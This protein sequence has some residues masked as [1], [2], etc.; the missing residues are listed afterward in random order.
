MNSYLKKSMALLVFLFG[1]C[2]IDDTGQDAVDIEENQQAIVN[3]AHT[4]VERQ[5]IGNCWVYAHATWAESMHKKATGQDFDISQSYWTYMHWFI[6]ILSGNF[7]DGTELGTGG[8]WRDAKDIAL[9]Y[10]LM[11]EID[12]VESDTWQEKSYR[13]A[14]ALTAMN[15]ALFDDGGSLLTPEAKADPLQVRAALDNAWGLSQE[16]R[17]ALD[18]T[19]GLALENTFANGS[20]TLAQ[21][22]IVLSPDQFEVRYTYGP[23]FNQQQPAHQTLKMAFNEWSSTTYG[24]YSSER[25]LAAL[26]RALHAQEPA[27]ISWFVDFNALEYSKASSLYGSFNLQTLT[28]AGKPG[29]Q[30]GHMTVLEDYEATVPVTEQTIE[31]MAAFDAEKGSWTHFGPFAVNGAFTVDMKG[32]GDADLYVGVNQQPTSKNY[33][34]R[35]YKTNSVESCSLSH[36]GSIY[37]SVHGYSKSIGIEIALTQTKVTGTS[38][39]KAGVTLDPQNPEDA[40]KLAAALGPDSKIVFLRI[41]NSWGGAQRYD[42]PYAPGPFAENGTFE[43]GYHD[44]YMDY[45]TASIPTV[46]DPEKTRQALSSFVL[47]PGF[48]TYY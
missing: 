24:S 2:E 16:V 34:C 36:A 33:K 20:A 18:A 7:A 44:L 40:S 47:P 1:A 31:T 11:N 8:S 5:S 43:K 42:L 4:P 39:L 45:L 9:R 28:A 26:K 38:T 41:K 6:S 48:Y 22:S 23:Y 21:D 27:L 13:Q 15:E 17:D 46:E 10:G 30:G 12:F 19:F 29:R 25:T 14:S 37:I 3:V 35:P 32:Q